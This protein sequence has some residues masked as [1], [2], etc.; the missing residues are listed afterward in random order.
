MA[1]SPRATALRPLII[2]I[3]LA[4]SACDK[5]APPPPAPA[6]SSN[7]IN[8]PAGAPEIDSIAVVSIKAEPLPIAA[9]LN[10]R[11]SVDESVTGRVGAP[12]A[13]RVTRVI[14]DSG[15]Q[16][17]AGQA[18]AMMDAPDL[19]QAR[20]DMMKAAAD[21]DFK[22]RAVARARA[23]FAGD[24]IAR[25][26]V[27]AA[28]ADAGASAA[29]LERA[30]LRLANLGGGR[31]DALALTAPVSGYVLDRQIEA[32]QQLT[33]GQSPLFTVTDPRRLWLLV[34]V[35]ETAISRARV[36][37]TI[38]FNVAA[39]P[40]RSFTGLIEKIGLAVDPVTRRIQLRA[41]VANPDLALKPDMYARSRLVSD[42]GRTALKVPNAALFEQGLQSYV[43]RVEAPGRYRRVPVT[44]G[45]RGDSYSYVVAGLKSGDRIVG[46]GALLLNAQLAGE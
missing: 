3:A 38:E 46:E 40:D 37:E 21:N 36:G 44:V 30:R 11:L 27:E 16:V 43:F 32:G 13:G 22:A 4:L 2:C 42:D 33:A 6:Q 28:T 14:A 39:Y 20:A 45:P 10:A 29:E 23:L 9:D 15:Q 31:G 18:L 34:D 35:P 17:R 26:D 5:T 19:A 25:R 24:A 1:Y 7:L 8:Y 41:S 12:V